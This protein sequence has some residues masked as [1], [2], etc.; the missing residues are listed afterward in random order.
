MFFLIGWSKL[1]VTVNGLTTLSTQDTERRQTI[2]THKAHT[3]YLSGPLRLVVPN[4]PPHSQST[5]RFRYP[6]HGLQLCLCCYTYKFNIGTTN[7]ITSLNIL[8]EILIMI[9]QY[10]FFSFSIN[11]NHPAK[12][13]PRIDPGSFSLD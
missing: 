6:D 13:I 5:P 1:L 10:L 4:F 7:I 8:I 2:Q 12:G 11:H 9:M 3:H